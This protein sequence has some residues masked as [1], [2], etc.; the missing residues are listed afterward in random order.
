MGN[1]FDK[2]PL[3]ITNHENFSSSTNIL[4]SQK[5]L[6]DNNNKKSADEVIPHL[7][8]EKE[9]STV[10]KTITLNGIIDIFSKKWDDMQNESIN[11]KPLIE[12]V[13][14]E[15]ETPPPTNERQQ[16]SDSFLYSFPV[17][18][19]NIYAMS[20]NEL[21]IAL[22]TR[23]YLK[24]KLAGLEKFV[25]DFHDNDDVNELKNRIFEM[26]ELKNEF[27]DV[28]FKII[29]LEI[30]HDDEKVT[31]EDVTNDEFREIEE[32]D[33]KWYTVL[34]KM[35]SLVD[36]SNFDIVNHKP[37][38][39]QTQFNTESGRNF[40]V[41]RPI[42]IFTRSRALIQIRSTTSTT[43]T[44]A[45]EPKYR[46]R[47][48]TRKSFS[49]LRTR[50]KIKVEDPPDDTT[51]YTDLAIALN[52]LQQTSVPF[53]NFTRKFKSRVTSTTTTTTTTTTPRPYYT[54]PIFVVK[55]E[56][57]PF[58]KSERTHT[59]I[60]NYDYYDDVP[61]YS[62]VLIDAYG[63]IRCLDKGNF[64]HPASCKRFISCARI[65]SGDMIGW[66]YTCPKN[67]SFDP[68][69]GD[70]ALKAFEDEVSA[71]TKQSMQEIGGYKISD[72]PGKEAL[73]EPGKKAGQM[74]M[75]REPQ[76]VV[77][78]T[79]VDEGESSHWEKVG[80]VLGSADPN[81]GSKTT[82]EGKPYDFVFTVDVEDGKPPLKLPYNKGEDPYTA[83]HK[84]LKKNMLPAAYLD[85][86]V[87]FIL[88]NSVEANNIPVNPN[89]VDPFVEHL[90]IKELLTIEVQA[91]KSELLDVKSL[92]NGVKED[93]KENSNLMERFIMQSKRQWETIKLSLT[94]NTDQRIITPVNQELEQYFQELIPLTSVDD[95]KILNETLL[96]EEKRTFFINRLKRIGERY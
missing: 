45:P 24:T 52:Q 27:R 44:K 82:F 88:T 84:F 64:P 37:P 3:P 8:P 83:A 20:L 74:K 21:K 18:L 57:R 71:L 63:N 5:N 12:H 67:L 56:P 43:T 50:N 47:F 6:I 17:Y 53:R 30:D 29:T 54:T 94:Y 77:A 25:A 48:P 39:N 19:P 66:E 15:W 75:I 1:G 93:V 85:Q 2:E 68:V 11:E 90:E 89:Y 96:E 51:K 69:G 7:T 32:F 40:I 9:I 92:I 61:Q 49:E 31:N 42:N 81:A 73:Y 26:T 62:Q 79:W 4:D 10:K 28:N 58:R 60:L 14:I 59:T 23:M 95:L 38:T 86:V 36:K 87:N 78:Y 80:D 72:L 13:D 41:R 70:D 65:D 55:P 46:L 35:Q 34:S 33:T 16:V 91:L 76:G 22:K